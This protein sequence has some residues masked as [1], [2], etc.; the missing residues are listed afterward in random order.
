MVGA[1][2]A[3]TGLIMRPTMVDFARAVLRDEGPHEKVQDF[4][5]KIRRTLQKIGMNVNLDKPVCFPLL[6]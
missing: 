3:T 2:N 5:E 1:D 4:H 6:Y